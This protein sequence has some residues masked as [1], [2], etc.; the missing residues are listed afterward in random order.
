MT[1]AVEGFDSVEN[2]SRTVPF[3][4][5]T[6]TCDFPHYS[7]LGYCSSCIDITSHIQEQYGPVDDDPEVYS[8]NY[9]LPFEYCP[10]GF[11]VVKGQISDRISPIDHA[12]TQL[13]VCPSFSFGNSTFNFTTLSLIWS[14]CSRDNGDGSPDRPGCSRRPE[15]LPSLGNS[16][17]MVARS[18]TLGPCVRDYSGRVRNGV[19]EETM[20]NSFPSSFW[21]DESRAD[22]FASEWTILKLPCV[23]DSRPYDMSNIS[24][25]PDIP[26]RKFTVVMID[27]QEVTAPLEC[28][29]AE[30]FPASVAIIN[31]LQRLFASEGLGGRTCLLFSDNFSYCEPWYL[32]PMFRSGRLTAETV[33]SDM[34]R[35]AVAISNQIRA[36]GSNAYRNGS[37]IALGTAIQTTVCIRVEWP[38]LLLPGV[39]VLLTVVLFVAVLFMARSHH[40]E[41]P[42]WKSSA[43][44]AF[45]HGVDAQSHTPGRADGGTARPVEPAHETGNTQPSSSFLRRDSHGALMTLE[46]MHARA[47]KVV[48]KLET[49]ATGRRGFITVSRQEEDDHRNQLDGQR[50]SAKSHRDGETLPLTQ[51]SAHGSLHGQDPAYLQ[52][53]LGIGLTTSIRGSLDSSTQYDLEGSPERGSQTSIQSRSGCLEP[54]E[55]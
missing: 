53:D 51:L 35:I 48:V 47:K 36:V 46:S 26:G 45:F 27:G 1:A 34:D 50:R 11:F 23:V 44:V 29:F 33:S 42:I 22:E 39:L 8:L 2:S 15:Q 20:T 43:L 54:R 13:V 7:S 31:F 49:T 12:T 18:C 16:S 10:L 9:T 37:G 55:P 14:D 40:D 6:G 5:P 38:W 32:E 3:N 25:V 19:L 28:I 41:K 17:G 21:I 4:C 24:Q 52:V 30:G